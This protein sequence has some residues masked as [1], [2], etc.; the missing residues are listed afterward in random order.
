MQAK[1]F[2]I[3]R[4]GSAALVYLALSVPP[5]L[6]QQNPEVLPTLFVTESRLGSGIVG[7]S[8]TVITARD[9]E[10]SPAQSLSDILA[11][12]PGV[13]VRNLFGGVGARESVDI[14]GFGAAGTSNTLVLVNGR[15]LN[16][17]DMAGVDFAAIPLHSVERIEITRGNSGAVLYGD[18]A[19]GGVIN[20]V[21]KNGAA[22]PSALRVEAALGS[23]GYGE[24]RVSANHSIGPVATAV[25]GNAI[26][27]DGYRVN[28]ALRQRDGIGDIRYTGEGGSAYFN[29]SAD[30]Q[31]L[32]LP[33]GRRVTATSS[34]FDTDPRGTATPFDYADKQGVNLTAG[35]TRMLAPGTELIVDGG[36]RHKA[37]QG[38][39]F[40][41]F[42]SA[43]DSYVDATLTT[44]SLT[45]R[46]NS[47]HDLF[48][49]VAKAIVG[50]DI[51]DSTYGSDRALHRG[52]SPN[53]RY[54][55]GQ[56]TVG[57]YGQETVALRPDTDL[58]FG[59]RFQRNMVS[60]RDRLDSGAPGGFFASPQGMPL[61]SS[62]TQH[63]WHVGIEHRISDSFAVFA[64]TARSFRLPNV[65]ERVGQG[66]FGVATS[67][68][69]RTQTSR[70]YEAGVRV[71]RSGF[72]LQTSV[73][74]MDL[75]D[76]LHFSPATF[77]NTNLDPT[78]RHGGE[79]LASYQ[80]TDRIRLKGGLAYTRAIFREGLFAG[81]DVP[82]VSRWTGSA[83]VAW[84][85]VPRWLTLD[86]VARYTGERRLDNDQRNVQPLIPA[87]TVVDVR[88]GGEIDSP[89]GMPRLNWSLAVQNLFDLNYFNYGIASAFTLG[90]YD[91]YPQPGRTFI[92]RLGATF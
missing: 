35:V 7:S 69:L 73:Y 40:S 6:A 13:Q 53:H 81:N 28:N 61:D 87:S 32:G 5:A 75:V 52:D 64:R 39:F 21:T 74:L 70:D 11:R 78:R 17:V 26:T 14:R 27:S 9:I 85:I 22:L 33:G 57:V 18:G 88:V 54:D 2:M 77:T 38:G 50:L 36:L 58:A 4:S 43:F 66:P 44:Y 72:S 80:V 65:D 24:A 48:G 15:R 67:F 31:H 89:P 47:K 49:L 19:V 92:A 41:A 12:E 30:D 3:L 55:L 46:L 29:I 62:E 25:F 1:T 76:E 56:R 83:G 90:T 79:T 45:P 91:T 10:R 82:L 42:G 8:T 51:Y 68:D 71:G 37:Q 20:I 63:A 23:Y 16:D 84:D 34:L 60:A 59:L 86:T